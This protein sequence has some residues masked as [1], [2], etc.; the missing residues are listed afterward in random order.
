MGE[1]LGENKGCVQVGIVG[2]L[3]LKGLSNSLGR[4][5]IGFCFFLRLSLYSRPSHDHQRHVDRYVGSLC[6]LCVSRADIRQADLQLT[7]WSL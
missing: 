5:S 2:S 6:S 1:L 7:R 3:L 4:L